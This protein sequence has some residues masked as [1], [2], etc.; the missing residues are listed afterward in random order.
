M[1]E[2]LYGFVSTCYLL[3]PV[4][5]YCLQIPAV[6]QQLREY[7]TGDGSLCS[8]YLVLA[9]CNASEDFELETSLAIS[10]TSARIA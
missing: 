10:F 1:Y 6:C 8:Q 9:T 4:T 2:C 3:L 7:V 5:H